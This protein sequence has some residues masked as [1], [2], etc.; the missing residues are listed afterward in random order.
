MACFFKTSLHRKKF[1][2]NIALLAMII[3]LM[4]L[5]WVVTMVRISGGS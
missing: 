4:A 5:V 2:K 3:G 1:K